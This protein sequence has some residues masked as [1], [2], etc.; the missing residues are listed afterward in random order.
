MLDIFELFSY[1]NS[2]YSDEHRIF[3]AEEKFP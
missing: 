2:A 3:L 1:D